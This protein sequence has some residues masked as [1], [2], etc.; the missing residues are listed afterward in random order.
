MQFPHFERGHVIGT[1]QE[2]LTKLYELL[3]EFGV[4]FPRERKGKRKKRKSITLI[5]IKYKAQSERRNGRQ[6][7]SEF[8]RSKHFYAN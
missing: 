3:L 4:R 5:Y 7:N 1:L 6:H 8:T 2:M